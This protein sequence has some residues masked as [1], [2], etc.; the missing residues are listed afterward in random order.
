[1]SEPNLIPLPAPE[2]K[3]FKPPQ[4]EECVSV[5]M[6]LGMPPEEGEKFFH[7]HNQKDW[8]V[9]KQKMKLWRS[10]IALWKLNWS[11]WNN[12]CPAS[13]Q[14]LKPLPMELFIRKTELER[15]ENRMRII[16]GEQEHRDWSKEDREEYKKLATRKN[17]LLRMLG[18]TC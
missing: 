11:K 18:M 2:S 10:A 13:M 12:P 14:A 3:Q 15:V 7:Y 9:G 6:A 1:M 5:A 16:K 4:I 8:M 17:E